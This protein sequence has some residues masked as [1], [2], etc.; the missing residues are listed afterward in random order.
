ME[1]W[2]KVD[3][4]LFWGFILF[5][6]ASWMDRVTYFNPFLSQWQ[7]IQHPNG[8]DKSFTA[9]PSR[10]GEFC[11]LKKQSA[12]STKSYLI[13]NVKNSFL[14]FLVDLL[15]SVNKCLKQREKKT[16]DTMNVIP[17]AVKCTNWNSISCAVASVRL[18]F[19]TSAETGMTTASYNPP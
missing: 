11:T 10:E 15:C 9:Q 8:T 6:D 19:L 18:S 3:F 14:D 4:L 1:K 16:T 13:I 12:Q 7:T 2:M 5:C 17:F